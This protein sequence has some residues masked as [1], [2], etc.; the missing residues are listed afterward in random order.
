MNY[1]RLLFWAGLMCPFLFL[2]AQQNAENPA[3]A[4]FNAEASDPKA[5]AIA[6]QVMQAMGGRKA[7]DETRHIRWNFFG[8]RTIVWDKQA[9][10]ARVEYHQEDYVALIRLADGKGRLWLKGH[11]VKD[12][13]SLARLLPRAMSFWINDSYWVFMPYKLKDSGVTLTWAGE[14]KTEEGAESD[15]LQLTFNGVGQTP[16]NKYQVWVDKETHLISQWA[17]F[18]QQSDTE[19][20]FINPWTNYEQYG[21]ILLSSGRGRREITRYAVYETLPESIYT[22]LKPV[23]WEVIDGE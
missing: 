10:R 8:V 12:P 23:N 3:A 13:D 17:F 5:I 22:S 14:G 1:L 2:T 20:A 9:G 21:N 7:W 15:I 18:R 6:D 19:P 11:E 16:Q 4:G